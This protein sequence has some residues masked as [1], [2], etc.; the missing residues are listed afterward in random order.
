MILHIEGASVITIAVA[1]WFL[2]T[3]VNRYV[4]FLAHYNIPVSVTG[5]ILCSIITALLYYLAD[6]TVEF[7]L[8]LRDLLLLVFFLDHRIVG[9][10][11]DTDFGRQATHF[12]CHCCTCITAP[13][14]FCRCIDGLCI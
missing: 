12:T 2:G 4:P 1:V 7:D 9:E 10:V 6:I 5:G 8:E 14:E 11:Q 3:A 13:A